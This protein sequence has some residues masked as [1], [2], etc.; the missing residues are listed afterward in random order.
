MFLLLVVLVLPCVRVTGYLW[1]LESI[2]KPALAGHVTTSEGIVMSSRKYWPW[3]L[4]YCH[5]QCPELNLNVNWIECGRH[6]SVHQN[7]PNRQCRCMRTVT[8]EYMSIFLAGQGLNCGC[9]ISGYAEGCSDVLWWAYCE[10]G[11]WI[12]SASRPG[13]HHIHGLARQ[14]WHRGQ[15]SYSLNNTHPITLHQQASAKRN[16]SVNKH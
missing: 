13:T 8:A 11:W 14:H 15:A 5:S 7:L 3:E 9:F 16:A 1:F 10:P 2:T 12:S 4:S 6:L